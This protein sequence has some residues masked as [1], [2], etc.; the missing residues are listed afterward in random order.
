MDREEQYDLLT[1]TLIGVAIGVGTTLLLRQG[2]RGRPISPVIRAAGRGANWAGGA[3]LEGAR[4]AGNRGARGARWMADQAEDWWD[5]VP[6]EEARESVGE[7]IDAA[8]ETIANTV[9]SELRDLRRSIRR[10]RRK[11]GV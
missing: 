8:K 2:P 6:V 3:G 7:Y 11:L 10:K 9:E 1:A 5:H 4:W